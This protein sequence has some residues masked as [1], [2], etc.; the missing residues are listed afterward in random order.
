[1]H[2][3][4]IEYIKKKIKKAYKKY[5]TEEKDKKYYYQS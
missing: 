2:P 3:Y 1:M 4:E 5:T